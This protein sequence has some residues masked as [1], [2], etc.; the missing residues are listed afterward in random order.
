MMASGPYSSVNLLKVSSKYSMLS[1]VIVF[2]F[3]MLLGETHT[4][5]SDVK[6]VLPN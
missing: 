1:F 2:F 3:N 5:T 4:F 6:E